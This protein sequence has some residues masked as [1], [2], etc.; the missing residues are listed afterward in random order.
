MMHVQ[1]PHEPNRYEEFEML[2]LYLK[3]L[4][5][6]NFFSFHWLKAA[7]QPNL[8]GVTVMNQCL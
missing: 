5:M 6:E 2:D 3:Q 1:R 8:V 7:L 4:E